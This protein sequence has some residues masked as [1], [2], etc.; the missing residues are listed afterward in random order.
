MGLS[1]SRRGW[2]GDH[3]ADISKMVGEYGERWES[4]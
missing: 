3:I 4:A 1:A 2:V